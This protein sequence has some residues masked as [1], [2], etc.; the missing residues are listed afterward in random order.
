MTFRIE[1]KLLINFTQLF[2]FKKWLSMQGYKKLYPD[3]KIKSLYFDNLN[4][5]MF[6]DSEEGITPRK[7]IRI[8]NYPDYKDQKFF[9]E[10]KISSP[11]GRFKEKKVI[12]I[13]DFENFKTFG[14]FDEIYKS[15]H[16]KLFVD[17]S[18]EYF[19]ARV[20]RLTIDTNIYYTKYNNYNYIKN[21]PHIA[22]EIK[23]KINSDLDTLMSKFPFQRVR[24]SKYCRGFDFLFNK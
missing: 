15:C 13:D 14:Y 24:F 7:K 17:Y 20:C 19:D 22:V 1:E 2:N 10:K 11:E 5:Q 6:S 8:R 16:P 4:N 18:R 21:D 12:K 9:L 23:A 3:R